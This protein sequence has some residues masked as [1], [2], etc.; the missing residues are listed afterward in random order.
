[1]MAKV[2]NKLGE[3]DSGY[4]SENDIVTD[5][6]KYCTDD[7]VVNENV[8]QAHFEFMFDETNELVM[9]KV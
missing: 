8:V 1:M 4:A 6:R 7:K 3:S 5:D 2:H 9:K